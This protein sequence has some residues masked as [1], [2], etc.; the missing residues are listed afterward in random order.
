MLSTIARCTALL[1]VCAV[2]PARSDDRP[3][4]VFF[5]ADDVSWND[6]GCYGNDAA[7]TPNIDQLAETGI[8]FDRAYLTASSCSPSRSSI[9]TGRYPHNNGKGAELH[10]PISLPLPWF[11]EILKQAGYYTAL[12]GKH[13][14]TSTAPT[15]GQSKRPVAFDHVDAGR[16]KGDSSG[17]ANWQSVTQ[18]RPMDQPFFFWFA[19]YDAHRGWDA[20]G[21]W[22]PKLYGPKH[23]PQDVVVPPFLSDDEP[24]RQDLASY[25]NEVTRF[26]YRIGVVVDELRKQGVLDNTLIFVL[27]DNGRPFP[28]AKTR[29]HDSGMKTA[30]VAHWPQGIK[31]A[32][33]SEQLVSAIDLA[34]TALSVAGCEIPETVQG[35]SMLPLFNDP[36]ATIRQYA[37]SEH[38]WHDYEAFGRSVRDGDYLL[39]LNERP[40]LAWQGPADSVRSDSHQQLRKLQS[41]GTLT[42]AQADVFLSPR[43]TAAL[44][45]VQSDPLQLKNLAGDPDYAAVEDKLA[46]VLERWMDETGDSVPPK[47]SPDT[48]D[49]KTGTPLDRKSVDSDGVMTPG[50]DRSADQINAP[51]PR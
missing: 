44:Y 51:G 46:G 49:R 50:Q 12:S 19:S 47:L 35:V 45:N 16:T 40:N 33:P 38:N 34:P 6:Y 27:A 48:F 9:I 1:L 4:I 20:D 10:Q 43:P 42:P 29:L 36:S 28:R 5:I 26:D 30:L 18:Q 32:G 21:Q 17:S 39:I 41:Q 13:H 2:S 7:R 23:Q 14:M 31:W 8:R 24:T 22:K 15:Q 11:P 3:N 37:F 25:Y